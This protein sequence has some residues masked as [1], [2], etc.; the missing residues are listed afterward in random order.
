M[1]KKNVPRPAYLVSTGF[2]KPRATLHMFSHYERVD[3]KDLVFAEGHNPQSQSPGKAL[4]YKCA[5]T[6]AKR[7]WGC[8]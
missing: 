4:I 5:E 6:G 8:E 1:S 2:M 7:R 3:P